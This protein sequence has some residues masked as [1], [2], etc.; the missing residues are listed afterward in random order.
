MADYVDVGMLKDY[1]GNLPQGVTQIDRVLTRACT[2]A[3]REVDAWC[4]RRFYADTAATARPFSA[5]DWRSVWVDDIADPSTIVVKIDSA[6][7]STYATTWPATD[8]QFWPVISDG[9]DWPVMRID[10]I[11]STASFPQN[12]WSFRPTVQVTAKWGWPAVPAQVV[13]AT[14]M[15]ARDLVKSKDAAYGIVGF[16]EYGQMRARPNPQ[17]MQLLEP[18]CLTNFA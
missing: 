8:Y 7:D 15:L 14:L 6:G 4:G 3:S 9:I 13:E 17:A 12:G 16:A 2:S 18:F 10:A 1:A 11:G 5:W